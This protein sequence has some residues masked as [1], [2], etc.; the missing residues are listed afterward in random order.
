MGAIAFLA[1]IVSVLLSPAKIRTFGR[2]LLVLL[3][4]YVIFAPVFIYGFRM[5]PQ[6]AG[7][8]AAKFSVIAAAVT[9]FDHCRAQRRALRLGRP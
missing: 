6:I 3:V 2:V 1:I 9:A 5:A 4:A 7:A 8:W